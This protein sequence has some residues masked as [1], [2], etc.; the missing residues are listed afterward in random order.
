MDRLTG[1]GF[2]DPESPGFDS[3]VL[4]GLQL[5]PDGRWLVNRHHERGLL[6]IDL[7]T[8]QERRLPVWARVIAWSPDS[9]FLAYAPGEGAPGRALEECAVCLYD[10]AQDDH[11]SLV[12]RAAAHED[13]VSDVWIMRWS[14]DGERLA[15]G[16][17]FDPREPYEGVSDGRIEIV[18]IATRRTGRGR[19]DQRQRGRRRRIYLLDRSGGVITS[20]EN[21]ELCADPARARPLSP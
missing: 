8:G 18:T 9:R 7:V 11:I 14:P 1:D 16:C 19:A 15:Y 4:P 2:M 6:L 10:L 20:W 21:Q 17:C 5:S 3:F 13:G 12:P